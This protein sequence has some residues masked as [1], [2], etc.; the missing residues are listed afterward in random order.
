MVADAVAGRAVSAPGRPGVTRPAG[1]GAQPAGDWY[2][3]YQDWLVSNQSSPA[4]TAG[5]NWGTL[6]FSCCASGSS[7][8]AAIAELILSP[9]ALI[10]PDPGLFSSVGLSPAAAVN[11][12]GTNH[13]VTAFTQAASGA[14]VPGVTIVFKVLTGPNAGKTGTGTTGADGKTTFT[15][16]DT[17]GAGTDTIQAFIGTT[18]SSNQV[19]KTWT[20]VCD[21]DG[22]ADIDSVDINRIMGLLGKTVPPAPVQADAT[23]DGVIS[24]NDARACALRCTRTRCATQ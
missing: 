6:F 21:L 15:Y 11:P 13:T 8:T 20:N 18:L 5:G 19:T 12:V 16:A 1:P 4:T 14:P 10:A 22:D 23:G 7:L 9:V 17:G 24:V 3:D 2:A